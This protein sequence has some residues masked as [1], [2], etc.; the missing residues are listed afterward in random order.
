MKKW[1]ILFIILFSSLLSYSQINNE[2]Y[3]DDEIELNNKKKNN[4]KDDN[5]IFSSS[6]GNLSNNNND[7]GNH[8]NNGH[9]HG[10]GNDDDEDDDE[11]NVPINQHMSFLFLGG[12]FLMGWKLYLRNN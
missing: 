6:I 8:G 4:E 9:G 5:E 12:I 2:L 3:F 1:L 10:H 7:N 11:H